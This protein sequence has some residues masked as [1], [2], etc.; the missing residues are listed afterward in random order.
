MET[1]TPQG[2]VRVPPKNGARAG[3]WVEMGDGK[4][5]LIAPVPL[6]KLRELL[7]RLATLKLQTENLPSAEDVSTME[8]FVMA[9]LERNYPTISKSDDLLDFASLVQAT[10]A[11]IK[12][13]GLVRAEHTGEIKAAT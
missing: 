8:D 12:V 11:A 13:S 6:G 7:P 2:P 1:A 3:T 9:C 4:E 10:A 5:Y